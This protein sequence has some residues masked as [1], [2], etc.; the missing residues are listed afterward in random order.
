MSLKRLLS[1][2]FA[3]FLLSLN[4]RADSVSR[5]RAQSIA[6]AFSAKTRVENAGLSCQWDSRDIFSTRSSSDAT[7]YVFSAENAFVIVSGE[8]SVNPILAYSFTN[9]MASPEN[10]PEPV[11]DWLTSVSSM[12]ED[13]RLQEK[14]ADAG[15]EALWA[16]ASVITKGDDELTLVT[17]SW[18]QR[19]P[20]NEQCPYDNGKQCITG[21][22]ATAVGIAM[23][24]HKWPERG[25]GTTEA[26]ITDRGIKVPARDLNHEYD[27]DNM[28]SNYSS[29]SY[30]P[31]QADAVATLLADLGHSFM[32]N[33]GVNATSAGIQRRVLYENFD[34]N[35]GL[36]EATRE[37]YSDEEWN[38]L[39]RNEIISNRPVIYRGSGDGGGHM[40]IVNGIKDEYFHINWGWG[41]SSDGYFLFDNLLDY[42]YQQSDI[43][44]F[45]PN[46]GR[47]VSQWI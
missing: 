44:D 23:Y 19:A 22:V 41:G 8:D 24:Y 38:G 5:E 32:A 37:Y 11:M 6:D 14:K 33:Y 29:G 10:L 45:C 31:K 18:G 28:I 46:E 16:D 40:F 26:Y 13:F 30:T 20:Y 3:L 25:K 35:P 27:W 36:Y 7:F 12:I 39:I 15:I 21:C 1:I 2:L 34:Y 4:S 43:I 47:K 42:N 17:A 9:P